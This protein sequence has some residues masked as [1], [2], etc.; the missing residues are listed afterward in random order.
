MGWLGGKVRGVFQ[1]RLTLVL[2]TPGG[3]P[4]QDTLG[5]IEFLSPKNVIIPQKGNGNTSPTA[6]Y[7]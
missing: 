7:L 2:R 5:Q 4:Q 6:E 3:E 1:I